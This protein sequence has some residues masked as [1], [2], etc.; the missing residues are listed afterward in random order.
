MFVV[1]VYPHQPNWRKMAT[2]FTLFQEGIE[3]VPPARYPGTLDQLRLAAGMSRM[4]TVNQGGIEFTGLPYGS[5][6]E[7]RMATARTF[8]VF[9]G[10]G[11]HSERLADLVLRLDRLGYRGDYSFEVFNDDYQQLPLDTVAERA[12]RSAQW[13]NDDVLHRPVPL[14]AWARTGVRASPSPARRGRRPR[15]RSRGRSRS[16]RWPGRGPRARRPAAS[17]T[18]PRRTRGRS[19]SRARSRGGRGRRSRRAPPGCGRPRESP[20]RGEVFVTRKVTL[21]VL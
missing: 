2:P 8:R 12:R 5:S 11:V 17:A 10:E 9:P 1:D 16:R 15:R 21:Q 20:R 6:F 13:L 14:P 3:R 7:E 19:P 4:L 18:C